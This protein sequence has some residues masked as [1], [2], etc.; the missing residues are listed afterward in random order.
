LI[1]QC[2]KSHTFNACKWPKKQ[3]LLTKFFAKNKSVESTVH[4]VN[5]RVCLSGKITMHNVVNG[6]IHEPRKLRLPDILEF[7]LSALESS[8]VFSEFTYP[9]N[10]RSFTDHIFQFNFRPWLSSVLNHILLTLASDQK[11]KTFLQNSFSIDT[12]CD[13]ASVRPVSWTVDS[14]DLFLAKNFVRRFCFFGH[15]QALKV[16]D[17][18]HWIIISFL[19]AVWTSASKTFLAQT[20]KT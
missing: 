7:T 11:N 19:L 16:C 8:S 17:L 13:A 12:S 5:I 15:L 4:S 2:F 9:K 1:I 6:I 20:V 10:F 18:K 3:N 14:T